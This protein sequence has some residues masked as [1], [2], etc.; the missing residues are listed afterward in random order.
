MALG[1]LSLLRTFENSTKCSKISLDSDS[2]QNGY[3]NLKAVCHVSDWP[4]QSELNT[5]DFFM[6]LCV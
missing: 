3:S 5:T 2:L 4:L 6:N 1:I